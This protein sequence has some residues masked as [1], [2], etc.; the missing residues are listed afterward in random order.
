MAFD[1]CIIKDYLL[2]QLGRNRF[3]KTETSFGFGFFCV[4]RLHQ[5]VSVGR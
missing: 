1:H 3:R 2:A 4:N 5:T